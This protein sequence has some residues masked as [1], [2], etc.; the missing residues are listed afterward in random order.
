MH[1]VLCC[2]AHVNKLL[3]TVCAK[4]AWTNAQ[5]VGHGP[6]VGRALVACHVVQF[7][8]AEACP[9]VYRT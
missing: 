1:G 2:Q 6:V 7:Y 9:P 8:L 5:L 3:T 4:T